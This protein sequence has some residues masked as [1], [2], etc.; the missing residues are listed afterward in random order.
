V[1]GLVGLALG[2]LAGCAEELRPEAFR[3]TTITGRVTVGGRA[4]GPGW[5][6]M[7]PVDGTT[8]H[9]RS[10]PVGRDG[11]FRA[12]GVPVGEVAMR[13]VGFPPVGTGVP[14]T[15]RFLQEVRQVYGIRRK[16]PPAGGAVAIEL[17]EDAARRA[18]EGS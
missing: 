8:G 5:L 12:E 6:E 17:A 14:T 13:L 4:Y 15:D 2:L 11:S 16:V 7:M 9:L 10:A 3:T 18:R 1:R